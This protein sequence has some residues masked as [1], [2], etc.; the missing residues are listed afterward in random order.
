MRS[1]YMIQDAQPR[2][3]LGHAQF[4]V[5]RDV[6]FPHLWAGTVQDTESHLP[7]GPDPGP[8]DSMTH[9]PHGPTSLGTHNRTLALRAGVP[10]VL[11]VQPKPQLAQPIS[12]HSRAKCNIFENDQLMHG[13]RVSEFGWYQ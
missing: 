10:N 8:M 1:I 4:G 3:P 5:I 2:L 11:S 13:Q 6:P 7:S 12:A 9:S